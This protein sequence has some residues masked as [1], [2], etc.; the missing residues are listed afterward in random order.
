MDTIFVHVS[1]LEKSVEW[2][3]KLLGVDIKGEVRRSRWKY[4][5]D[6]YLF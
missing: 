5:Y 3:G 2:Y 1:D 4:D 6:M